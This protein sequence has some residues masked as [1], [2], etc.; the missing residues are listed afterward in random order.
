MI[1]NFLYICM[2]L[3]ILGWLQA[4]SLI[5][6]HFF[7]VTFWFRGYPPLITCDRHLNYFVSGPE[8]LNRE[9]W[10]V[11]KNNPIILIE[12]GVLITARLS[13][14]NYVQGLFLFISTHIFYFWNEVQT[15]R[16]MSYVPS[17]FLQQ[18]IMHLWIRCQNPWK[19]QPGIKTISKFISNLQMPFLLGVFSKLIKPVLSSCQF[20]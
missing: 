13:A 12:L 16:N 5:F 4:L 15:L 1:T 2:N 20:S 19:K 3:R 8:N 6:F 14:S 11:L 17:W 10:E 18:Q 7:S 9:N